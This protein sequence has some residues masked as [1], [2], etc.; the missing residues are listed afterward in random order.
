[1]INLAE[2]FAYP[3]RDRQWMAKLL[4][5][6]VLVIIPIFGWI[7]LIGYAVR[8]IRSVLD[9]DDAL[10]E[11]GD[12]GGD[13]AIGL[14]AAIGI[15]IYS[16]PSW[17]ISYMFTRGGFDFLECIAGLLQFGYWLLVTPLWMAALARYARSERIDDFLDFRG[18]WDDVA[19]H[20][21]DAVMLWLNL[22]LLQVGLAF[23]AGIGLAMCC[24][25]G[26][27]VIAAGAL[28]HAHL[29]AQ[30]GMVIGV[31]GPKKKRIDDYYAPPD[32]ISF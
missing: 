2:A 6:L 32:D 13:A 14:G 22:F 12:W 24:I 17:L 11:Y 18:R 16:I 5:T 19:T 7:A 10:P 9:G 8:V 31:G 1:M 21:S 15:L 3:F 20:S 28:I 25:P 23:L 29:T 4:L 26:L 27:A 30:W